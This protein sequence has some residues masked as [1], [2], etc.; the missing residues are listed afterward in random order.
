MNFYEMDSG[1][2]KKLIRPVRPDH[3]NSS[4]NLTSPI[5]VTGNL[6]LTETVT[7]TSPLNRPVSGSEEK[8]P[9]SSRKKDFKMLMK[10]HKG[11]LDLLAK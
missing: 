3:C 1:D 7:V 5:Q 10:R 4:G 8:C 6:N 2:K 9:E 11:T